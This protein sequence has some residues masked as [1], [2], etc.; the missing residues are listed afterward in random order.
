VKQ[1]G[2]ADTLDLE[3]LQ[4]KIKHYESVDCR[5]KEKYSATFE[6]FSRSIE[7]KPLTAEMEDDLLDWK[8]ALLMLGVY[9]KI[10]GGMGKPG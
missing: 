5:Y 7:G 1:T 3:S 6:T 4:E 10:L 8:E 2:T 9:E